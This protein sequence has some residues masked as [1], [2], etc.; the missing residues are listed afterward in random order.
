MAP[1][2]REKGMAVSDH[3]PPARRSPARLGRS[4]RAA[5]AVALAILA[6]G[7]AFVAL[8]LA[9]P[10]DGARVESEQ[11]AWRT[12]GVVVTPLGPR[13]GGLRPGDVVVAVD[14]RSLEA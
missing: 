1:R 8:C 6:L 14:G 11:P 3:Q 5:L 4:S 10:S 7:G 2:D 9:G 12:D 13:T